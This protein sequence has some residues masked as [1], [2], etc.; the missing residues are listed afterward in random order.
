MYIGYTL[1]DKLF[2]FFDW[3][4]NP[5]LGHDLLI[6]PTSSDMWLIGINSILSSILAFYLIYKIK[7]RME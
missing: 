2:T 1:I 6:M 7:E 5:Q 3:Y 4:S